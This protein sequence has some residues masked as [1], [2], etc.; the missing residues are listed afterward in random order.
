[1]PVESHFAHLISPCSVDDFFQTYWEAQTLHLSRNDS[2]FYQAVLSPEDID[3]LLQNKA[4]LADYNNFRLVDQGHQLSLEDWCDRHHKSQ[5][6]FINNDKLYELLH[7]GLTLTINGAHKKL[8]KLRQF[9]S[10]LEC[11][12]KF[13]LR[14]NLYITPPQA[15]GLAPH[16]DEH[17]VFILQITGTKEWQLYHAPIALPSHLRDQNIGRHELDEPSLTVTL[18]PGDLLYIP[19]GI[20]H[21][22]TSQDTTSIHASLGLY[23]TFAYELL[24]ELV[25][26]A[27][28]DPAFRQAIPH[29]FSSPD[30]QQAFCEQF[31][32]LSQSLISKT[33]TEELVE[34]KYEVFRCDR[35]SEDEGRFRDLLRLPQLTLESIVARRPTILFK[36]ETDATQVY[37]QFYQKKLTFPR[38][39]EPSLNDL[40][41]H[42]SLA[43][44]E[45]GGLINDAGRLSLAK[46][47]IQAGF[48]TI[49]ENHSVSSSNV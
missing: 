10:A 17:D 47:L 13:K 37:V 45:I 20:V 43:V 24:E 23:P 21:Q 11:E 27:Q 6:Y 31:Q 15:R 41:Q 48:L 44:K 18:Q 42:P 8:P 16:Y 32:V 19:R 1:M 49:Q 34:K 29:G 36:V 4:L 40:I 3:F 26:L 30:Q 9:C 2:S 5:Q 46:T 35:K 28:A 33:K 14:T 12:L 25:T 7:Q 38:F 22:A 39:L